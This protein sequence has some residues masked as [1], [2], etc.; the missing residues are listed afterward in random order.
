MNFI[1]LQTVKLNDG[2]SI[3]LMSGLLM[4]WIYS[5]AKYQEIKENVKDIG[6][7][8]DVLEKQEKYKDVKND[9]K[10]DVEKMR[11][12]AK[13]HCDSEIKE[14]N[15][16]LYDSNRNKFVYLMDVV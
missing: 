5:D 16:R 2:I 11:Q 10:N 1:S 9:V 6:I 7:R 14:F 13:L 15:K 8:L 3:V 12:K 4:Y